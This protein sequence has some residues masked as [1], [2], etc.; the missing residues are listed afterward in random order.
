VV[1]PLAA[2]ALRRLRRAAARLQRDVTRWR[3]VAAKAE[4]DVVQRD[5]RLADAQA[6]AAEHYKLVAELTSQNVRLGGE[7]SRLERLLEE[8]RRRRHHRG[9]G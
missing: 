6:K 9:S 4:A 3:D 2:R 1:L 7:R 5:L 8:A